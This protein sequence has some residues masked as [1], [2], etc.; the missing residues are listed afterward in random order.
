MYLVYFGMIFY[1]LVSVSVLPMRAIDVYMN[2]SIYFKFKLAASRQ[3]D[4]LPK[5]V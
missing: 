1:V 5:Y 2:K 4:A 3:H